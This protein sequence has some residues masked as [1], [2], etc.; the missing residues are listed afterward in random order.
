MRVGQVVVVAEEEIFAEWEK[1]SGV[2]RRR[3][4][5]MDYGAINSASLG[6][7]RRPGSGWDSA[8]PPSMPR[9]RRVSPLR[10]DDDDDAFLDESERERRD[11]VREMGRWSEDQ[12][13]DFLEIKGESH[14][15]LRTHAELLRRAVDAETGATGDRHDDHDAPA[16][17]GDAAND[18]DDD[19]DDPFEAFMAGIA[20]E[21]KA[22]PSPRPAHTAA[23]KSTRAALDDD[24]DDDP[25]MSFVRARASGKTTTAGIAATAVSGLEISLANSSAAG[26]D[27]EDVYA[28][29]AAADAATGTQPS[30]PGRPG[31]SEPAPRVDH[32]RIEYRDFNRDFY[33]EAPDVSSMDAD[34]VEAMR[35]QLDLHVLGVDPPNPVG[36]F[37]QCG[38]FGA[39]TL[40]ILKRLGYA[41]PTPIQSQAIPALLR[42][43]DV[44]GIAKTGSGK[45]AAF[46]LPALVHAMDQPE[47]SKGDGPIVLVLAP[48]RELGSQILAEC[49]KLA[50]AHE[51]LRCVGVLG[52]G[53]KTENF[54][55]LRAGAEVVVGT[56]GRVVDVCGG[57]A[58][59][60]LI[61]GRLGNSTDVVFCLQETRRRR[62]W[63]GSPTSSST[64]RTAC[65]TWASRR[66]CDPCATAFGPIGRRRCSRRRC[67]RGCERCATTS[68]AQ[69]TGRTTGRSVR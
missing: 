17:T 42:G 67:P 31:A 45:T 16:P 15:D 65:W 30:R 63:R 19:D 21:V 44:V 3:R 6:K 60:F 34:A 36:R 35:R 27:D 10:D 48:T 55:E 5:V 24:D 4:R 22:A 54:R 32:S 20:D 41:I 1:H 28:A 7:R 11:A 39:E 51:G 52:G 8:A 2:R 9:A 64:R 33:V 23:N 37:G 58:F 40:R 68:S 50:R 61:F 59:I 46:L 13:R 69:T 62:T 29:A 26:V 25:M 43:R 66:R 56:P 14:E 57:G 47:L 53:S 18:D 49:K 38:G 12:L